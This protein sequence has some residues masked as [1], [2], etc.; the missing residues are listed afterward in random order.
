M[1]FKR[2]FV[3]P[4]V[5]CA[6]SMV[7]AQTED[8]VF[9]ITSES[10]LGGVN[11]VGTNRFFS[12]WYMGV[13]AGA[14]SYLG[15]QQ[16]FG[17]FTPAFDFY[18]GKWFTPTIGVRFLANGLNVK[19]G[20]T[21][22][23]YYNLGGNFMLNLSNLIYGYDAERFYN[24][25]PYVGVGWLGQTKDKRAGEVRGD[26]GLFNSFRLNKS[27][28][29]NCD[30][31]GT[32]ERDAFFHAT[33][34]V[35]SLISATVGVTYHFK[36]DGF[37]RRS[38]VRNVTNRTGEQ[39]I[40]EAIAQRKNENAS[41]ANAIAEA[42]AK[43]SSS[44]LKFNSMDVPSLLVTFNTN[45]TAVKQEDRVNLGYFA[46]V[47]KAGDPKA[48]YVITGY[49]DEKSESARGQELSEERAKAIRNC[50][51][52]EFGLDI[53]QLAVKGAG[54]VKAMFYGDATLSKAAIIELSK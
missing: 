44:K 53:K 33:D 15:A 54:A 6:V 7:S 10:N 43:A 37:N 27:L 41:L 8:E 11:M 40:N 4:L 3:L 31:R 18:L 22:T 25:V 14:Q 48:V 5:L 29:L 1:D 42:K 9:E 45:S 47:V 50:L 35:A 23:G 20:D 2:L 32:F 17:E 36:S 38:I 12:D 52:D 24:C 16:S 21:K 49:A 34:K 30:L 51:V 28:D 19:T 13:G 46:T 39:T 26:I